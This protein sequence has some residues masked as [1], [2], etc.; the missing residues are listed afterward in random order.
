MASVN[1]LKMTNQDAGGM[2]RHLD[3]E[4]R[5]SG[6][7]ANKDIDTSKSHL[8]LYIG[9][10]DYKDMLDTVKS[11]VKEVDAA[12]PP[13][14]VRKDRKTCTMLETPVP[15]AIADAGRAA[16]FMRDCH[17]EFCK[18]FGA[19]N[20]GGTVCHFDEVHPYK[21]KNGI[22]R[23][24]LIHGHTRVENY[25]ERKGINGKNFETK[26]RL[27]AVNKAIHD[28]CLSRYGVEYNT[29]LTA[30]RIQTEQLKHES[31]VRENAEKEEKKRKNAQIIAEQEQQQQQ[32][33][34]QLEE[35]EKE[36]QRFK[37][38]WAEFQSEYPKKHL[39][40]PESVYNARVRLFEA[41]IGIRLQKEENER[42]AQ[43]IANESTR[44]AE[45]REQLAEWSDREE[46][47]IRQEREDFEE[48]KRSEQDKLDRQKQYNDMRENNL[49]ACIE[50]RAEDLNRELIDET[51]R[52][53]SKLAEMKDT[54]DLDMKEI[55]E[56]TQENNELRAE[57]NGEQ[58]LDLTHGGFHI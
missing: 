20:V 46:K 35:D 47:R 9:A 4:K 26:K 58:E 36:K 21:D 45:E 22:E 56:L 37:D 2:R 5:V 3:A 19:E 53:K 52:L 48:Y 17:A 12:Y 41:G 32:N 16:E 49:N 55:R 40:E 51:G 23:M 34:K 6:N 29:G 8:N 15:Q 43:N 27:N 33:A 25:V 38:I 28:M 14:S 57:L 13:L 1:W 54:H 24:S 31:L 30:D 18:Y 44:L 42:T 10:N 11:R 50:A 39:L 7:H